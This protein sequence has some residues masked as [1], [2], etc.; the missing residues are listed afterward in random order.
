VNF[1]G[2][3][4]KTIALKPAASAMRNGG[5]L[6]PIPADS[7]FYSG[8]YSYTHTLTTKRGTVYVVS[9]LV[10]KALQAQA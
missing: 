2:P 1:Y 7:H 6:D 9:S 3:E 4:T 8:G 5:T 10:A